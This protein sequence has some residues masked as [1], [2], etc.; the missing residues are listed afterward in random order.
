MHQILFPKSGGDD[1]LHNSNHR[2]ARRRNRYHQH[3]FHSMFIHCPRDDS[4][5][6]YHDHLMH[7]LIG[8]G[9]LNLLGLQS[10]VLLKSATLWSAVRLYPATARAS[11]AGARL[12]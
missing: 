7:R 8:W 4:L 12:Q 6:A 5:E 2:K 3:S 9:D 11:L 1:I 10:Q